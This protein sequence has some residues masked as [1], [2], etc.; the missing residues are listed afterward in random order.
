MK[1]IN[2]TIAVPVKMEASF[3]SL[4]ISF[5]LSFK[6]FIWMPNADDA[7]TSVVYLE[8]VS[9]TS[10]STTPFSGNT[11]IYLIMII[12]QNFN[13]LKVIDLSFLGHR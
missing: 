2:L 7:I 12:I 6:E 1:P 8:T 3:P 10:I 11:R 4:K 9:F 13:L 5:S